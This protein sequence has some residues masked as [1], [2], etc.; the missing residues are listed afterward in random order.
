MS[1]HWQTIDDIVEMI[2]CFICLFYKRWHDVMCIVRINHFEY[3]S[4]KLH[5]Y[6]EPCVYLY[7]WICV[8]IVLYWRDKADPSIPGCFALH[9][10][11]SLS[12][13]VCMSVNHSVFCLLVA[14][15]SQFCRILRTIIVLIQYFSDYFVLL[16]MV[17][18]KLDIFSSFFYHSIYWG[19]VRKLNAI[20]FHNVDLQ[21]QQ[22]YNSTITNR[23]RGRR[24][25]SYLYW[26]S[27]RFLLII[28]HH[29]ACVSLLPEGKGSTSVQLQSKIQ[30]V[31]IQVGGWCSR[32][33]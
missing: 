7:E 12:L 32:D 21:N 2:L 29:N 31:Q 3:F 26:T 8:L 27:N 17:N 23:E 15:W 4:N 19:E 13:F 11:Y 6:W 33:H 9:K 25:Y 30:C 14:V 18:A 10:H 5:W 20:Q 1:S 22:C 28:Y 24:I 16:M